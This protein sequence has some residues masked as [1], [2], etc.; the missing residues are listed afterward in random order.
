MGYVYDGLMNL[1]NGINYKIVNAR[2]KSLVVAIWLGSPLRD[3]RYWYL[4][5]YRNLTKR[6]E[7]C[8]SMMT[9]LINF[10]FRNKVQMFFKRDTLKL[11]V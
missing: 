6:P 3:L 2:C 8:S 11:F 1:I 7:I 10:S 9:E 5:Y 4:I